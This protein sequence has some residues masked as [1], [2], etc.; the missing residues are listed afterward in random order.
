MKRRDVLK[1]LLLAWSVL[2]ELQAQEARRLRRIAIVDP[3]RPI[4]DMNENGRATFRAF[5]NRLRERGYVEGRN[6]EIHRYTANN[7]QARYGEIAVAAVRERPDVIFAIS[8]WIAGALSRMPPAIPVVA[9]ANDPVKH[10]IVHNLARPEKNITGVAPDAGIELQEKIVELL[11]EVA[12]NTKR[13]KYLIP[14]GGWEAAPMALASRRAAAQVG[15]G[16]EPLLL[17]FKPNEGDYRHAFHVEPWEADDALLVP[18]YPEHNAHSAVIVEL[19][20]ERR[21]PALYPQA[22]YVQQ[23]GLMFYGSD[24]IDGYTT[25]ANMVADLLDGKKPADIPF[26]QATKFYLSVNLKTAKALGLSIPPT[27]LARADEVVE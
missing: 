13:I 14:L 27:L 19:A 20:N 26:Q 8:A 25:S 12:P 11:R 1:A 5:L 17:S 23:G 21:L 24:N 18:N 4:S 16:I 6:L 3:S 2:P 22:E 7:D 10:G 15:L 9:Y